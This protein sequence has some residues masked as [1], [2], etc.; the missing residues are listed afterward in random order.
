M[1]IKKYVLIALLVVGLACAAQPEGYE[2]QNTTELYGYISNEHGNPVTFATDSTS[3]FIYDYEFEYE[4]VRVKRT[5]I[6][7][8]QDNR[9]VFIAERF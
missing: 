6:V 1:K 4:T 5:V 9:F 7:S 2:F 3:H 8:E